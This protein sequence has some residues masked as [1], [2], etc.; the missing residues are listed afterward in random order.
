MEIGSVL[1]HV[2]V[3][4]GIAHPSSED[5]KST[6]TLISKIDIIKFEKII[7]TRSAQKQK[8]TRGV[9]SKL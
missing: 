1:V 8:D 2:R 5:T 4:A 6:K 3:C 7:H 9:I